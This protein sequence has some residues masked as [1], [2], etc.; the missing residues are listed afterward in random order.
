MSILGTAR[1]VVNSV[2]RPFNVQVV[3]GRTDDPAVQSFIPARTTIAA[4]RAAG[5]SVGDYVDG[6]FSAPGTSAR[7]VDALV[8]MSG[9]SSAQRVCEIGPGT[10][11]YAEKVIAALKPDAYEIYE[12]ATDWLPHL[13]KLP[14]AVIQPCDGHT[15]TPTTSASVDLVHANKV[16]VYLPFEAVVGYLNEMVR[17][18]RPGGT[19]AFDVV[20]EPCLTDDVVQAWSREG[21]LFRPLPREWLIDYLRRRGASLT[22]SHFAQLIDSQ[23]ELL[24]FRKTDAALPD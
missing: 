22:G 20:T 14:N 19:I 15:L 16:F 11:R 4:A 6:R 24:V 23:T 2:L 13:R 21:T 12:T 9:L 17:V 18:A 5:V 3:R 10:G 7:T 1:G 8:R